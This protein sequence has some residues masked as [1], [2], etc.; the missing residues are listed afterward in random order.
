M[1]SS[2]ATLRK[3]CFIK[4]QYRQRHSSIHDHLGFINAMHHTHHTLY[5]KQRRHPRHQRG[6][7]VLRAQTA[8]L[9]LAPANQPAPAHGCGP[10]LR[11]TRLQ[12]HLV[13]VRRPPAGAALG[14]V[15]WEHTRPEGARGTEGP[16]ET[17]C[18]WCFPQ[19]LCLE[20][21]GGGFMERDEDVMLILNFLL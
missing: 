10:Q 16:F 3:C 5:L 14:A 6:P 4:V 20:C 18:G 8:S 13:D 15:L 9:S 21:H 12:L 2:P 7:S 1:S 11:R 19:M 17:Y